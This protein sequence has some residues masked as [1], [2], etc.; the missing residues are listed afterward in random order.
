MPLNWKLTSR[1]TN[2]ILRREED[3]I[4]DDL[5]KLYESLNGVVG[6]YV[7]LSGT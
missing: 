7:P 6:N 1:R 3:L 5:R 4:H 2:Q